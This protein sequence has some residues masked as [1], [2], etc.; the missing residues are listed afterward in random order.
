MSHYE[1]KAVPAP[2]SGEA[3]S[4]AQTIAARI[5]SAV[6]TRLNAMAS[7]G[8]SY[9]R[10]DNFATDGETGA[11]SVLIFRRESDFGVFTDDKSE[12]G[13]FENATP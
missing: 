10:T 5:A 9:V 11:T 7:D 1:Y 3:T 8:W 12:F 13:T 4:Q 6:E 2:T